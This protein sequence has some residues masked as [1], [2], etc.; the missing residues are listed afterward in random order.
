L[1]SACTLALTVLEQYAQVHNTSSAHALEQ[2]CTLFSRHPAFEL[3]C[4]EAVAY[5]LPLIIDL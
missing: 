2:I 1:F 4:Q 3:A 5:I